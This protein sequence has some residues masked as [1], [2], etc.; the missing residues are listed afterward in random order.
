[1][2]KGFITL[3]TL[4]VLVVCAMFQIFVT[5]RLST[6]GI[7]L[8]KIENQ[9]QSLSKENEE[10]RH[11]IASHSSL[12]AVSARAKELGFRDAMVVYVETPPIARVQ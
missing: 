11:T 12:M 1:M 3:I 5:H 10:L 6:A 4:S 9:I 7:E 8:T 2:K